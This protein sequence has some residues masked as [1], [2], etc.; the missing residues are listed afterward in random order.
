MPILLAPSWSCLDV[1][2]LFVSQSHSVPA[3]CTLSLVQVL[4]LSQVPAG[5]GSTLCWVLSLF[6]VT[7]KKVAP[8]SKD[9]GRK[10]FKGLSPS[11]SPQLQHQLQS[12]PP[13]PHLRASTHLCPKTIGQKMSQANEHSKITFLFWYTIPL[14]PLFFF[15]ILSSEQV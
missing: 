9:Q 14:P 15:K 1:I 3:I 4:I 8:S 5:T 6:Q 13:Q 7:L 12:I 11:C 2:L 10:R